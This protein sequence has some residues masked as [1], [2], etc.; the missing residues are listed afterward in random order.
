VAY[1]LHCQSCKQWSNSTTPL[2]DD[3][4]CSFCSKP[5]VTVEP[6]INSILDKV[7]VEKSKELQKE[8][9]TPETTEIP[10]IC[11]T[12]A[13][14]ETL[15]TPA[16]QETLEMLEI[17]ETPEERETTETVETLTTLEIAETPEMSDISETLETRETPKMTRTHEPF[18]KQKRRM[19]NLR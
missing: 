8:T 9:K 11:K 19:K 18:I 4:S 17:P 6:F 2:S 16:E 3:K 1:W 10:E 5:F 7:T 13:T 14:L 12:S 15:E